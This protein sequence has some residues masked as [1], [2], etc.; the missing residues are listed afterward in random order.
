MLLSHFPEIHVSLT[1]I[2]SEEDVTDVHDFQTWICQGKCNFSADGQ[3]QG[4]VFC[5]SSEEVC[6]STQVFDD[7]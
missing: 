6:P 7:T 3:G 4:G 5:D 1:Q 2:L